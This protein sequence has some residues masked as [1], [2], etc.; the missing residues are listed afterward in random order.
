M[1]MICVSAAQHINF[2]SHQNAEN[3]GPKIRNRDGPGNSGRNPRP[4]E[5]REILDTEYD[6]AKGPPHN[7]SDPRSPCEQSTKQ[8]TQGARATYGAELPPIISIVRCPGRPVILGMEIH[9]GDPTLTL[10]FWGDFP[11]KMRRAVYGP[12]PVK[13]ETF[14]EL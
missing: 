8:G 4:R 9:F 2:I 7:G 5:L 14:R 1:L 11:G 13:T 6:R 10:V 12:I 3:G